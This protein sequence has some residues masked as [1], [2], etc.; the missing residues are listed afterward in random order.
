[1]TTTLSIHEAAERLGLH[2]MTVYR[3]IRTG[4]LPARK[5]RGSWVIDVDDLGSNSSRASRALTGT[6][7]GTVPARARQRAGGAAHQR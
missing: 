2:Y 6:E 7:G 5:D 3:Y 1:M 4:S